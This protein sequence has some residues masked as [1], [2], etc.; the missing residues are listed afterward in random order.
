MMLT[1]EEI[2]EKI[3]AQGAGAGV[4][5]EAIAD[6]AMC[7]DEAAQAACLDLAEAVNV[8]PRTMAIYWHVSRAAWLCQ[9]EEER[10]QVLAEAMQSLN[11]HTPDGDSDE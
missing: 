6:A 3:T 4:E 9:T 5:W 1:R 8:T 11:E 10:A 7:G 2:V